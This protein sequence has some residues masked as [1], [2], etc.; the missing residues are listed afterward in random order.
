MRRTKKNP[1]LSEAIINKA[2]K[3]FLTSNQIV[4]NKNI[5]KMFAEQPSLINYIQYLDEGHEKEVNKEII[6]LLYTSPSPRDRTRS[7]M[8]SSA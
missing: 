6:C 8:P 3:Y 2:A 4:K 5:D 1:I 7:R